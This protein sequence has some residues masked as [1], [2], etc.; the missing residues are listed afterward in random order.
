VFPSFERILGRAIYGGLWPAWRTSQREA[1]ERVC[2]GG[3]RRAVW[4]AEVDGQV[5][6]FVAYD[7]HE[8]QTGEVSLLAVDPGYQNR[9]IGTALNAFALERMK[10]AGM[11]MARVETGG[12]AAHAPARRCYEK[13]GYTGLPL[14]RYFRKL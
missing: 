7:L 4:V 9:G 3:E 8:D 6:G 1:V 2:E 14:V 12:D 11:T 10:E 5:V 13:A